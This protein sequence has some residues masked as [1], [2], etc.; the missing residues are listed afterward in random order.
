MSDHA[1]DSWATPIHIFQK[2]HA[3][4]GFTIDVCATAENAKLPRFISPEQDGLKAPW[5]LV[6]DTAWCNPPYS[7]PAPW[8]SKADIEYRERRVRTV[9]LLNY[10]CD[11]NYFR[12]FLSMPYVHI[13]H[14]NPRIQFVPPEDIEASSNNNGQIL[15]LFGIDEPSTWWDWEMDI[16]EREEATAAI[17]RQTE[18]AIGE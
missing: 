5:G 2:L 6:V 15:V 8:L 4:F 7:D 11:R 10:C 18:L 1:R 13:V 12:R 9:M 3:R 16:W 14:V 17:P